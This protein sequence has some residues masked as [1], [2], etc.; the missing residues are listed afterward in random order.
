MCFREIQKMKTNEIL[1]R[2]YH[3]GNVRSFTPVNPGTVAQVW[4]LE[5][6]MGRYLLRTLTGQAQG[7]L[8]WAIF[9]HLRG[10]GFDR[11]PAILTTRS[12][13]PMAELD[14]VWYQ[15]QE[16]CP[17]TRPDPSAPGTAGKIAETVVEL[18]RALAGFWGTAGMPDRF[19]LASVWAEHRQNWPL[20]E[21]PISL[22]EADRRVA[23]LSALPSQEVQL[24]HGDLGLWNMLET[25]N[26]V[27]VIDFGEA[28]MGDPYFD[29]AS[30]LAGLINHSPPE[31]QR[32]NAA[33]FLAKCREEIDRDLPRL[34]GQLSLWVWRGFAQCARTPNAWKKM[35]QRF[36]NALIWCE[37]NLHE[38]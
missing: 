5:T 3:L 23:E 25:G 13:V 22:E 38:L 10:A 31:L 20:L 1:C 16:Y 27:H 2:R 14:G 30:A 9:R 37:E 24:V 26:A 17:G 28:R 36:Y 8:E 6:D 7:E 33:E 11:S 12:G 19:D 15:V 35:A 29:L 32:A 34:T 21:L 4:N 18:T